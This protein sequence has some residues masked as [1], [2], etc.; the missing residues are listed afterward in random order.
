MTLHTNVTIEDGRTDASV[1]KASEDT[2][3]SAV[4]TLAMFSNR[5]KKLWTQKTPLKLFEV[6]I[7]TSSRAIHVENDSGDA[8]TRVSRD[9]EIVCREPALAVAVAVGQQPAV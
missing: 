9:P 8:R 6:L 7:V 2:C 5:R 4:R 1:T 3:A